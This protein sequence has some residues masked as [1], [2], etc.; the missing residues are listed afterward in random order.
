MIDRHHVQ[1]DLLLAS[2][3][4]YAISLLVLVVEVRWEVSGFALASVNGARSVIIVSL[5]C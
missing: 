2:D 1:L 5:T 3:L 4:V